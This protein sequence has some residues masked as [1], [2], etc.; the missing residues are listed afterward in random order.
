MST[1][2]IYQC[3]LCS[4]KYDKSEAVT[5]IR[6]YYYEGPW[7]ERGGKYIVKPFNASCDKHIC[8]NCISNIKNS[9]EP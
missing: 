6:G 5:N 3:N 7:M 9:I 4:D 8:T 1:T 2:T